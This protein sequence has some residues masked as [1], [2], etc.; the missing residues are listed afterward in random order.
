[1]NKLRRRLCSVSQFVADK[2]LGLEVNG[3][4]VREGACLSGDDM[5]LD[6]GYPYLQPHPHP[7]RRS[8]W[9]WNPLMVV[10]ASSPLAVTSAQSE[11]A[12]EEDAVGL[13][14]VRAFIL[15]STREQGKLTKSTE[16]CSAVRMG[17]RRS[18]W[19]G[20]IYTQTH[21]HILVRWAWRTSISIRIVLPTQTVTNIAAPTTVDSVSW[22]PG[23][24]KTSVC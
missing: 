7:H 1:M 23:L 10:L 17:H 19:G 20:R 9:W 24:L 11:G 6:M 4:G 15:P 13:G 22:G 18:L 5:R 8:F 14:R 12:G 21:I 2:G 3:A 16:E